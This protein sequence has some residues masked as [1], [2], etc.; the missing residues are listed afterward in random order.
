MGRET[1][2]IGWDWNGFSAF[3]YDL[4]LIKSNALRQTI[5]SNALK[6][7][8][9]PNN[10]SFLWKPK[11]SGITLAFLCTRNVCV[12]R[13]TEYHE[14]HI[15]PP[16]S[17]IDLLAWEIIFFTLS[18]NTY[19]CLEITSMERDFHE[20]KRKIWFLKYC[21]HINY[22]VCLLGSWKLYPEYIFIYT[23]SYGQGYC[24]YGVF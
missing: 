19:S 13:S 23:I 10:N 24:F 9:T 6:L 11:H 7:R 18:G 17:C 4:F 5:F 22:H 20:N 3:G 21:L 15:P 1:R 8:S 2:E 12:A 14:N 16:S